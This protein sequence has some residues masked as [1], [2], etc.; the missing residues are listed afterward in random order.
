MK[1]T[2]IQAITQLLTSGKD[3]EII[4]P[5]VK[6]VMSA[7]GHERL[8][9]GVLQGVIKALE[10]QQ[11]SSLVVI[12]VAKEADIASAKIKNLL[13]EIDGEKADIRTEIDKTLI[14]GA[15]A[16]YC[17]RQIDQTYKTALQKLYQAITT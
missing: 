14:G 5:R 3:I 6:E 15:K 8:Y 4:L 11:Q 10:Q 13:K 9:V 16:T 2:Y 1:N 17:N 7:R 12:Q